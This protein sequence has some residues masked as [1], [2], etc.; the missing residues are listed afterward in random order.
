MERPI[1]PGRRAEP[2]RRGQQGRWQEAFAGELC[3]AL[4]RCTVDS[5]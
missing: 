3:L 5:E 4:K 2:G 1:E